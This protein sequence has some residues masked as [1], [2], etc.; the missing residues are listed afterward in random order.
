[1][2]A[3]DLTK[4]RHPGPVAYVALLGA[5]AMGAISGTVISAP[6][7]QIAQALGIDV[8]Q[9]VVAIA[10]FSV[11]LVIG[12]PLAGWSCDRIGP[13]RFMVASLLALVVFQLGAALAPNLAVLVAMRLGQGLACAGVPAG[14][15]RA[16]AAH[17][18]DNQR[19]VMAA[20]AAAIGVGQAIG[21]PLGGAVAQWFGWRMIF[22]VVAV[23]VLALTAVIVRSV[24]EVPPSPTPID[25][26]ALTG[27]AV[28]AGCAAVGATLIGQN[29][30]AGGSAL[31]VGG[32]ILLAYYLRP[33]RPAPLLGAAGAS[34]LYWLATLAATTAM[35]AMSSV[36]NSVPIHLSSTLGLSPGP[37]GLYSFAM[38]LGMVAF[39]PLAGR[40]SERIGVTATLTTGAVVLLVAPLGLGVLEWRLT[41]TALLVPLVP[42]LFVIGCGVGCVAGMAGA[43]LVSVPGLSGM[44]MGVHNVARFL[45]IACGVGWVAFALRFHQPVVMYLGTAV[46]AAVT[47]VVAVA[48]QVG[49]RRDGRDPADHHAGERP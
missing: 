10:A 23:I 38:P 27:L 30:L 31:L 9:T 47:V 12:S 16:L 41:D 39:S 4:L 33:T 32:L 22:I 42:T 40:L 24:P 5:T 7:A 1:M 36:V 17:W 43:M 14:V 18:P 19:Q 29:L 2:G 11:A 37:I 15:Q 35:F 34:S 13:R 20:W 49:R 8:R 6:V 25:V 26:S 21:P 3:Q 44:A 28:G 48:W 45:G 46:L